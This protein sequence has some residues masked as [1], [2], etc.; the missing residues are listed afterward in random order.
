MRFFDISHPDAPSRGHFLLRSGAALMLCLLL[1]L[2]V[3][4]VPLISNWDRITADLLHRLHDPMLHTLM[5]HVTLLGDWR[6]AAVLL[7]LLLVELTR[8]GERWLAIHLL[9]VACSA[10]IG[11][12]SS[13]AWLARLRPDAHA[14]SPLPDFSFPSGHACTGV[15]LWG[16]LAMMLFRGR[17][18][19]LQGRGFTLAMLLAG[20]I[21]F[22]RLYLGRHW[23]SDVL[24]GMAWGFAL[25]MA[26]GWQ[27][28]RRQ[29]MQAHRQA[30]GPALLSTGS[31]GLVLIISVA[32]ML[33]GDSLLAE[34]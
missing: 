15:L 28:S 12:V 1:S 31:L 3:A 10:W 8:Q 14:L 23:P 32:W 5:Q 33:F 25:L 29:R 30:D 27:L 19:T 13:K 26:F 6:L 22:S 11:V 17:S 4:H 2:A 21:G 34:V 20:L 24:G 16:S 9:G 7:L 18:T